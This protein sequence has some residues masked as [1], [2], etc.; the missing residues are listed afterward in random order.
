MTQTQE[1]KLNFIFGKGIVLKSEICYENYRGMNEN[2]YTKYVLRNMAIA[3]KFSKN[4][5]EEL[6]LSVLALWNQNGSV[7][8]NIYSSFSEETWGSQS[9]CIF[10]SHLLINWDDFKS[11]EKGYTTN[12]RSLKIGELP[13]GVSGVNLYTLVQGVGKKIF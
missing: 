6:E 13:T 1:G 3:K 11:S 2:Y 10:Y 9:D 12:L 4:Q 7:S 8:K 5:L